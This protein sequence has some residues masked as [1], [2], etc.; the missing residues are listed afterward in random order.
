MP[1]D[2]M[3]GGM[4]NFMGVIFAAGAVAPALGAQQLVPGWVVEQTTTQAIEG[5]MAP[6]PST[7]MR[8]RVTVAG[9]DRRMDILDGPS[10]GE[11][12]LISASGRVMLFVVPARRV[13]RELPA[14]SSALASLV[15]PGTT[16]ARGAAKVDTLGDGP[17]ILGYR[18]RHYRMTPAWRAS[19]SMPGFAGDTSERVSVGYVMDFYVTDQ[20][21]EL[22]AAGI[23][24]RLSASAPGA[25]PGAAP[26]STGLA[27]RSEIH[28][29]IGNGGMTTTSVTEVTS[30][31]KSNVDPAL[32]IVPT[33]YARVSFADEMR[34]MRAQ[35]DSIM[36]STVRDFPEMAA[37]LK[38]QRDSMFGIRDTTKAKKP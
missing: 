17:V 14:D 3:F 35:T 19:I 36:K 24:Q 16:N 10:S 28:T 33:D 29:A 4:R 32:F 38:A 11:Y 13:V 25:A 2:G 34:A 20:L 26:G 31:S 12:T 5:A 27:L 21:P 18:T 22:G 8:M 23:L 37:R 9:G 6:M 30:V 7:Q 1:P 15:P